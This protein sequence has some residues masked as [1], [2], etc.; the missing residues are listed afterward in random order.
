MVLS[1]TVSDD[2]YL[3]LVELAAFAS[4]NPADVIRRLLD[5]LTANERSVKPA[6]TTQGI[7]MQT[8]EA[9]LGARPRRKRGARVELGGEVI[10]VDSVRDLYEKALRLVVKGGKRDAVRALLPYKTS[11]QRYLIAEKPKHPNGKSFVVPVEHGGLYMEAHKSYR[12]AVRQLTDFL[13][14]VGLPFR[15]LS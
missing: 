9:L 8:D 15:Y 12:I 13:S 4:C 6:T 7:F 10:E 1:R 5:S 14:R 11:S 2:I 3:R